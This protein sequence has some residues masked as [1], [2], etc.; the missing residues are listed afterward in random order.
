MPKPPRL[1]ARAKKI[2]GAEQSWNL[3]RRDARKRKAANL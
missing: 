3:T 1:D 2:R